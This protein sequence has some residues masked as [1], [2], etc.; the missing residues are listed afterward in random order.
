MTVFSHEGNTVAPQL[1]SV[2]ARQ[3]EDAKHALL[4]IVGSIKFLA[5]QGLALRCHAQEM[6]NLSLLLKDKAEDHQA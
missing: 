3:Q 2:V 5:Q 1:S 6:E 4:K